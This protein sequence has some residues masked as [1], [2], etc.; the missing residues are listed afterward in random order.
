[1]KVTLLLICSVSIKWVQLIVEIN[2]KVKIFFF[3]F[4]FFRCGC[5]V[6]GFLVSSALLKKIKI[7]EWL[8]IYSCSMG[9][10][11]RSCHFLDLLL[12]DF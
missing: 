9:F 10:S 11:F 12:V 3:F 1:M 2:A 8:L 7:V 5:F 4:F 6:V